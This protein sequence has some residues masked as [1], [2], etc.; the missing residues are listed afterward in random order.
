MNSSSSR[1]I[2]IFLC[3]LPALPAWIQTS[4][5]PLLVWARS[6]H[7]GVLAAT[8]ALALTFS[9]VKAATLRHLNQD[10]S[11]QHAGA[12]VKVRMKAH[13]AP[14]TVMDSHTSKLE[15][16]KTTKTNLESQKMAQ[17]AVEGYETTKMES[18]KTPQSQDGKQ[19]QGLQ[20][21]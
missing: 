15:A 1:R 3:Q 18:R 9:V 2:A 12:R 17:A 8:V 20:S 10:I 5:T 13:K 11:G 16:H 6:L 14:F 21:C 19:E 4:I 7:I